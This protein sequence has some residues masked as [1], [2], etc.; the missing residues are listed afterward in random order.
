MR[1]SLDSMRYLTHMILSQLSREV[2]PARSRRDPFGLS[3]E[4][5]WCTFLASPTS[6]P[7]ES[8]VTTAQQHLDHN[9]LH[10]QS[11]HD[12]T[13]PDIEL[14]SLTSS[15]RPRVIV[16]LQAARETTQPSWQTPMPHPRRPPTAH[17]PPQRQHHNNNNN[18]SS[19]YQISPL[20]Q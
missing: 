3:A 20:S 5:C 12:I 1:Y 6:A 2:K 10:H 11:D 16:P 19:P 15:G 18:H 9:I 17:C 13:T 14:D 8:H 7:A 4:S